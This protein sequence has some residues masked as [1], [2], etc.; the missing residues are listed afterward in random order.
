[1]GVVPFNPPFEFKQFVIY[2]SSGIS[3]PK[4]SRFLPLS[5]SLSIGLGFKLGSG[6]EEA[7]LCWLCCVF[8]MD[9]WIEARIGLSGGGLV[10]CEEAFESSSSI[11]KEGLGSS[12]EPPGAVEFSFS[13]EFEIPRFWNNRSTS[14]K[15]VS[16]V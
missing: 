11:V 3:E 15:S 6:G 7:E 5:P 2:S 10:E 16:L 1:M 13:R 8:L 14:G 4:L 9:S 12:G